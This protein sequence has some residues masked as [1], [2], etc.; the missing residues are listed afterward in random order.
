[1]TLARLSEHLS[2]PF[3]LDLMINDI[4]LSL[5]DPCENSTNLVLTD[6]LEII[7]V[8]IYYQKEE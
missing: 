3:L 7:L 6:E 2:G 4:V 8:D 1:M 5:F